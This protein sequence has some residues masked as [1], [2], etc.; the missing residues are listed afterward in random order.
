MS[1]LN[2]SKGTWRIGNDNSCVVT[3]FPVKNT[4]FPIPPNMS[5]TDNVCVEFYGGHLIA[6]SIGNI[7]DAMLISA[8]PDLLDAINYYF[9]V[10][11]EVNGKTWKNKPDHVTEKML[12]AVKKATWLETPSPIS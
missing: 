1:E 11:D 6:E 7:S 8:A 12:S 5:E 4:N 2:F 9:A 3:D 10:L